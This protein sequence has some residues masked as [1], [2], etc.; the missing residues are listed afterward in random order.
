MARAT[1]PSP[2]YSPTTEQEGAGR[3]F[4]GQQQRRQGTQADYL[5]EVSG[6]GNE[7]FEAGSGVITPAPRRQW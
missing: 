4:R 5:N 7:V 6:R 3:Y 2:Q 1:P